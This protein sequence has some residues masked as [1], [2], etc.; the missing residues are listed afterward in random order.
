[1]K[2]LLIVIAAMILFS[3]CVQNGQKTIKIGDNVSIDYTGSLMNGKVFDTSIKSIASENNLSVNREFKPI[4]FTVGKGQ[5]IKGFEDGIVGMK[6]GE[7][8]TLT[9]PPEKAYG[10]K[11]PQLIRS[12]PIIEIIP[13]TRTFPKVLEIPVDQFNQSFGPVYQIGKD[14]KIPETNI[15]LT[16]Q[17]ITPSN[18]T[19]SYDLSVGDKISQLGGPWNETVIK[20]DDK[21]ITSRAEVQKNDIVQLKG[22]PWNSTVIELD[23]DNI[24][25]RHNSIPDTKIQ[26]PNGPIKVHFNDT[27]I[28]IDQNNELAGETLIFSVT[29]KSI[30]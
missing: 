1:M 11:E 21:N 5:I 6:V 14:V 3:G 23:S 19:V 27:N 30:G 2:R 20:I 16:I 4:Q 28:I 22:A 7:S 29:V 17:N 13:A 25:L 24:T 18:I 8:K 10:P 26:S 15:N 9:I 12:F